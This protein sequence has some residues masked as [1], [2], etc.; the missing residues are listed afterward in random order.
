MINGVVVTIQIFSSVKEKCTVKDPEEF[1]YDGLQI[2][3]HTYEGKYEI[4]QFLYH[5]WRISSQLICICLVY[6]ILFSCVYG[7]E[8][9]MSVLSLGDPT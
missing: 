4:L 3:G 1:Q 8:V 6:V 9:C 7:G 5:I 2:H